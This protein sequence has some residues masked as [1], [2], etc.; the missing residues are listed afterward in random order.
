MGLFDIEEMMQV[1]G[2]KLVGLNARSIKAK[3]RLKS[4]NEFLYNADYICICESWLGDMD[5]DNL[6]QLHNQTIFRHDR[7]VNAGG[8]ICYV[9][10]N[11]VP[12]T[13]VRKFSM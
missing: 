4:T 11:F 3:G 7:C 12:Y 8:L 9:K 2:V 6:L 5:D 10:H 1:K 13:N